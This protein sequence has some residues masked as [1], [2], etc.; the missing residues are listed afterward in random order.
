MVACH[1]RY[2]VTKLYMHTVHRNIGR[3]AN[4][5]STCRTMRSHGRNAWTARSAHGA[6][7]ALN[8]AFPRLQVLV[9]S[10]QLCTWLRNLRYLIP[11]SGLDS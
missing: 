2:A 10:L 6:P 1:V 11:A 7:V 9:R 3:T 5:S 8:A 4:A